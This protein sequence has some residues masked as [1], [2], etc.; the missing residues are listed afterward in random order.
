M[1]GSAAELGHRSGG[2]SRRWMGRDAG[3][4]VMPNRYSSHLH[5]SIYHVPA[6]EPDSQGKRSGACSLKASCQ[7]KKKSVWGTLHV[8]QQGGSR[9]A[10]V[11][12]IQTDRFIYTS[13]LLSLC[14]QSAVSPQRLITPRLA[15]QTRQ[16]ARGLAALPPAQ[17][18]RGRHLDAARL[19]RAALLLDRLLARSAHV[20]GRS[21]THQAGGA[22]L[23]ACGLGG[24][25]EGF[26]QGGGGF[27]GQVFVEVVVDLHHGRVGAGAEALDFGHGEEAVLGG[28]AVVDAQRV[29][30]GLHDRVGVAEHAGGLGLIS[31]RFFS[32]AI[33]LLFGEEMGG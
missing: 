7:E 14:L 22:G 17:G 10:P 21:A 11:Q 15:R 32:C 6:L 29:F 24:L 25:L 31:A 23:G 13:P 1:S 8:P 5:S 16:S 2:Y 28:L 33:I 4:A 27:V 9:N 26:Q 20:G 12:H 3:A 19:V 18:T 30:A